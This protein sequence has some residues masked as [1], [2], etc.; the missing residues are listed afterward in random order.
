MKVAERRRGVRH[1][2]S[3]RRSARR[4]RRSATTACCSSATCPRR[5]TS[6]S[7][8]SATRRATSSTCSSAIARCSAATRRCSRKR[9]RPG[10]RPSGAARW[11]RR[12]SPPRRR[13]ATS[14]PAPSSSSPTQ[15]GTFFFMEMNT[16]LQVEHPVTEMI[17]GL[18][19]VEWQLRVAAGEPLPL[20]AGRAGDPRARDRGARLCRGSRAR[21]SCRRSAASSTGGCPTR[22]RAF[23]STP[24]YRAGDEVSLFYDPMLAKVI[25]WGEDRERARQGLLRA[26]RALRDRRR[27]DERRRSSSASS[28]TTRSPTR[29]STPG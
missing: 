4:A 24:A 2:R 29:A 3:R 27:D 26:L 8:C 22:A 19:L 21:T 12:R 11:A 23:A 6:R 1:R 20:R 17:T 15:D 9:P 5:A 16:R 13:S 14:A 18:D 25:A 28:P 10:C 7:R